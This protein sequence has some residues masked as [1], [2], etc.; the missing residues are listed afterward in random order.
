[1]HEVSIALSMLDIAAEKCRESGYNKIDSIRLKI[2]RASGVMTDALIFAFDVVKTDTIA[3]GASVIIDEIPV[4]GSCKDCGRD[5]VAEDTYVLCCPR[6]GGMAFMI[7]TGRELE[8]L[9]MEVS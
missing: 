7:N 8:I 2:G 6:C 4:S 1:M 5:F 3:S 9:D